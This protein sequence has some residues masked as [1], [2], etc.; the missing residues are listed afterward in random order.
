M[1]IH[2]EFAL[3]I[4]SCKTTKAKE[5]T[6]MSAQTNFNHEAAG[7]LLYFI[8]NHAGRLVYSE[9]SYKEGYSS[10]DAYQRPIGAWQV[11]DVIVFCLRCFSNLVEFGR[12][13][14]RL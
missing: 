9:K 14:G 4:F 2:K 11:E 13:F 12:G 5:K 3:D 7:Y 6:T 10:N 8:K 1:N